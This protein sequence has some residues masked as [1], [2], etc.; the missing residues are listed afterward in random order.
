[1]L[2]RSVITT[3]A[4]AALCWLADEWGE[5]LDAHSAANA[6]EGFKLT[7]VTTEGEWQLQ[8]QARAIVLLKLSDARRHVSLPL[9]PG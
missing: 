9:P 7:L 4:S 3:R 1:M 6:A 8:N 5:R 2:A